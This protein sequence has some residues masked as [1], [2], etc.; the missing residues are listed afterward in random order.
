[1]ISQEINDVIDTN[2]HDNIPDEVLHEIVLCNLLV[3]G[4]KKYICI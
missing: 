3:L 4:N 2:K 1:M